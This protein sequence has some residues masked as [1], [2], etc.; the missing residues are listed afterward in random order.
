MKRR[1]FSHLATLYVGVAA[2]VCSPSGTRAAGPPEISP[3]AANLIRRLDVG[4]EA[5]RIVALSA[6]T[7]RL[8]QPG[9]DEKESLRIQAE[10][11]E[12]LMRYELLDEEDHVLVDI[13]AGS[14]VTIDRD[15]GRG[16]AFAPV[17]FEQFAAALAS[18]YQPTPPAADDQR[19]GVELVIGRTDGKLAVSAPGIWSLLVVEPELCREHLN[20][21]LEVLHTG[22]R[23]EQQAASVE[24][25][26]VLMVQAGDLEVTAYWD[27]LV[28]RLAD[29]SFAVRR[30]ADRLL[31]QAGVD[32]LPYLHAVDVSRLDAEQRMR[33]REVT[34]SLSEDVEADTPRLAAWQLV[35]DV[36]VW[37]ALMERGSVAA[38]AAAHQRLETLL[39]RKI[40]F[41][42]AAEA[43][44][45]REIVDVLRAECDQMGMITVRRV[46]T[47][48]E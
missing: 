21:L 35:D 44:E 43:D 29:E 33:I 10:D 4:I 45:R 16:T 19:S 8:H 24:E 9:S 7:N 11:G 22:W 31:R 30:R 26:L 1:T 13:G 38:R 17:H 3:Q 20:P 27:D 41:D 14:S 28:T 23:L 6:P 46:S 34:R 36:S 47:S 18:G 37:L 42:A 2:I 48:A 15:P 5:G 12:T 39:G 32:V 40:D 25:Q